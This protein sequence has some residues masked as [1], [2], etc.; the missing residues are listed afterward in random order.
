MENDLD[1]GLRESQA[2][3]HMRST[4]ESDEA[5]AVAFFFGTLGGE[6]LGVEFFR[7]VPPIRHVVGVEGRHGHHRVLGYAEISE[8]EFLGIDSGNDR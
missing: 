8:F 6:T 4:T 7:V 5:V 2:K 1:L 3:T